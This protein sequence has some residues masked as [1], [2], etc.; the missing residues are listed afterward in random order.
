[1]TSTLK[2]RNIEMGEGAA[3]D[4]KILF[5]GNAQDFH[6]GLDDSSDSLTIGLGSTLGTTS[7]MV[8]DAN[9]HITKPLQP[10]FLARPTSTQGSIAVGTT[11][12][13]VFGT[14]IY[15]QNGD[16]ASNIFTAPIGGRYF[17]NLQVR[18]NNVDIDVDYYQLRIS[19]SNR[20]YMSIIDPDLGDQNYG[21]Y[22]MHVNVLADMDA[23]DTATPE[24]TIIGGANTMDI[25]T[26]SHFSGFLVC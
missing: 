26:E 18:M 16:F 6:I 24:I 19:T 22:S 1:M 15:D 11:T 8:I 3:S 20:V 10:A 25:H 12:T 5:D 9:G 23:S 4:S 17:L 2:V 13:I 21:M 14:E 7:H